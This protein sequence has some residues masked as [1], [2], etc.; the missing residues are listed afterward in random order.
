[1]SIILYAI[2]VFMA[3]IVLEAA[4]A[5]F[6]QGNQTADVGGRTRP[7]YQFADAVSSLQ[8]GILSR[9][10]AA[11]PRLLTLGIYVLVFEQ[12][13]MG[14]WD[15]KSPIAWVVALVI[16]DFFYY[17]KHRANHEVRIMWAG[18]I[19]HHNSEYFNLSTALRQSSTT[20]IF[21]WIFYLPMAIVGVPPAMFVGVALIDLLYQ[22]WVHTELIGRLG[23]FDRIFVSPSN[24]RVHHGQNDYCLDKNYGGILIVWDRL[25]G[26]YEDERDEPISY[27]VRTPLASVNPIWGNWHYYA[28]IWQDFLAARGVAGKVEALFAPPMGWNSDQTTPFDPERFQRYELQIDPR[29]VWYVL[30]QLAINVLL[31]SLFLFY[32]PKWEPWQGAIAALWLVAALL[33]PAGLMERKRWALTLETARWL[34]APMMLWLL[35]D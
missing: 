19:T 24:H 27:G 34:I 5:C 8:I 35:I 26:T 7:I 22:Y 4:W 23:W 28:I 32:F 15:L 30:V 12:F 18:H 20:F 1:M 33:A 2:P 16:Y 3:T 10:A 6:K 25:F 29:I 13:R 21:D 17:W 14:T 11:F 31:T 9:I